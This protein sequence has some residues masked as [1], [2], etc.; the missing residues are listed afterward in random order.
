MEQHTLVSQV[1]AMTHD[2]E[3]AVRLADWA[4]VERLVAARNPYLMS[5]EAEQSPESLLMIREIQAIDAA[6]LAESTQTR[7]ELQVEYR[8]AIERVNAARQYSQTA[9]ALHY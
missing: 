9:A 5:I 8:S 4:S 7:D 2:I 1:L 6:V 3:R